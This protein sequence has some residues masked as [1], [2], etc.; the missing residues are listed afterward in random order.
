M[1]DSPLARLTKTLLK[2]RWI[3]LV[4]WVLPIPLF[5]YGFLNINKKLLTI[6]G[7]NP[8]AQSTFVSHAKGTA[9]T[10]QAQ[11]IAL[12]TLH[13]PK[14]IAEDEKFDQTSRVINKRLRPLKCV[15]S[16][17]SY[18]DLP[19][20]E[21]W[22]AKDGHTQVTLIEMEVPMNGFRQAAL[23][24]A[25]L[26][27]AIRE[28]RAEMSL[29]EIEI[30]VTGPPA[31]DLDVGRLIKRDSGRAEAIVAIVAL[32]LLVWMFRSASAAF[33][34]LIT[35]ALAV[36]GSLTVIYAVADKLELSMYV[37]V[38]ASMAG[39]GL[40]LDYAL[41][42]VSRFREER[43]GG[44]APQDAILIAAST[45]GKAILG[46]G[47]IVI[48]GFAGLLIP[49]LN[50]PRSVGLSG[51]LV[52][53]FALLTTLTLLPVLLSFWHPTMHWPNWRWFIASHAAVDRF[54]SRWSSG[55]LKRPV[56]LLT[57]GLVVVG[58]CGP[59]LFRLKLKTPRHEAI[60]ESLDSRKGL[61]RAIQIMG[62]ARIYRLMVV[63]ELN[64]KTNWDDKNRRQQ[65][66]GV[67]DELRKWPEIG[68]VISAD[69]LTRMLKF[70]G[71]AEG[72][73]ARFISRDRKLLSIDI[74]GSD[75]SD[76]ALNNLVAKLRREMPKLLGGYSGMRAYVGGKSAAFYETRLGIQKA[77]PVMF[78]LVALA[79][80]LFMAFFFRS[81]VVPSKAMLL[82][83]LSLFSTFGILVLVFQHG[84][85]LSL[86]GY[87]GPTPG[88]LSTA[89][90]IILFGIVFGV[91]MDYEIFLMTRIQEAY[92]RRIATAETV[93]DLDVAHREAIHE[94]LSRTGGIITN[95]ALI[96][97][98]TFAAF[99]TSIVLPLKEMGFA[100]ALAVALDATLVRMILVPAV[101]KL[102]GRHTWYSPFN[103]KFNGLK[104]S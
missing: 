21:L 26:R 42:Y 39:L 57:L 92:H 12:V 40:G 31:I 22:V 2:Y 93:E 4:A 99:V 96:M 46:S 56:L 16:L 62:E 88:A 45:A 30:L 58:V 50:F 49:E 32:F 78:P 89:T 63:V 103:K 51:I 70:M 60:P 59:N 23:C 90:P 28:G 15:K 83:A 43:D 1:I 35:A 41:L 101:L 3:V 94:G 86:L 81:I 69:M 48:M 5:A 67:F 44:A 29:P 68:K 72:F 100:L 34:P 8:E 24:V 19:I 98:I 33:L 52:V 91:S 27:K 65:I 77:I 20:R 75:G 13:D 11:F 47:C 82:A 102:L 10:L 95:A 25:D 87:H 73:A 79:A 71:F 54:W 61:E 84:Y 74:Y 9:F 76:E 104:S 14:H 66:L 36:S 6:V 85:G 18:Q 38:I 37:S 7:S 17:S 97:V 80:F 55:V 64:D 53:F